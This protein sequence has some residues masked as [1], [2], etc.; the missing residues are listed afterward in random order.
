VGWNLDAN[1]NPTT[2]DGCTNAP[3][4]SP[5]KYGPKIGYNT[6]G[7][8]AAI[9]DINSD[10]RPDLVLMGIDNPEGANQFWYVVG[11]NL[12][13][14]GNPASWS[15]IKYGPKIGN[16]T[17]G[18]GAII[19]DI[20]NGTLDLIFMAIIDDFN[21]AD[22]FWYVIGKGLDENGDISSGNWSGVK[23][24]PI[25]GYDTAGGGAAIADINGKDGS[26]L[27]FMGIDNPEGANQFRYVIGWDL[28]KNGDPAAK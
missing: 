15:P 2:V 18:G 1:G 9:A 19:A 12:D 21:Q 23:H 13:A 7:G 11:W 17:A 16:D 3:C 14:S 22:Q 27:V 28:D 8:G 24:G 26:D 25:V 10:G 20:G 6:A 5:V 4:W